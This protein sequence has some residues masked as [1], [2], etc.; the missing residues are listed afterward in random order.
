MYRKEPEETDRLAFSHAVETTLADLRTA[1]RHLRRAPLLAALTILTLGL[2]IGATTAIFSLVNAMLLE[3]LPFRDP[4]R[5]IFVGHN[6]AGGE[7]GRVPVAA[8]ELHDL[9][10]RTTSF[11]GIGGIWSNTAMLTG[12]NPEELRIG[13]V[14]TD[15]F[16][17]LGASAALGRTFTAADEGATAT[18]LLSHALWQRRYGGDASVVGRTIQV[19]DGPATVIGVMPSG[20][21]TMMPPDSNIPDD[22]QA[23]LPLESSSFSEAPRGHLTARTPAVTK[24]KGRLPERTPSHEPTAS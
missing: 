22:L 23:W 9:R 7:L 4:E 2:G 3:D 17:V 11:D 10:E 8:A 16:E 14:T 21:R 15:F 12:E 6:L 5:L 13:F 20:F 24:A 19:S 1:L 18:I